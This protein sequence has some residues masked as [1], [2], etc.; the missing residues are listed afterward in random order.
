MSDIVER[1]E[2]DDWMRKCALKFLEKV[3]FDEHYIKEV[4]KYQENKE[5]IDFFN[6]LKTIWNRKSY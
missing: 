2:D 3:S 5:K 4:K 6:V 1:S